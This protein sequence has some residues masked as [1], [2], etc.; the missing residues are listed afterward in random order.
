[1]LPTSDKPKPNRRQTIRSMLAG[2]VL[3][4]AAVTEMLRGGHVAA[5]ELSP[6]RPRKP[7]FEGKAKSLILLYMSGGVSHIET[8]DPKPQLAVHAGEPAPQAAGPANHNVKHLLGPNWSFRPGGTCGTPVSDLFPHLRECMD[9]ICLVRSMHSDHISHMEATL[10][11]HTGSF[12]VKRPSL[13]AWVSYGLGTINQNLPSFVVLAP[14]LPYGGDQ[15]WTADFLP[16]HHQG[17][18]IVAGAE[19]IANLTPQDPTSIQQR[20]LVF[21]QQMNR[22]HLSSRSTD[23]TLAARIQSFETAFGMQ[24]EMP[25]IVDLSRETAETLALYDLQPGQ[26]TGFGWQCLMARRMVERG[27]RFIELIDS[28]SDVPN[29]WDSHADIRNQH[30]PRAKDVDQPIAGLLKDLKRRG[31]LDET[32]VVWTTEFGRTP[33]DDGPQGRSHHPR[34]FSSWLAGAGVK[35]GMIYGQTDDLGYT[36]VDQEVHVHDFHATILH[37]LGFDHERL[38]YRHA[39]RDFR[40]TDVFG[41]V[42]YDL[43]A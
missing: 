2:S 8:F 29:N 35:G 20:E 13:G 4:P 10:G 31:L 11:I 22:Q 1:M 7:H 32:L 40:L 34:A 43:L 39:G 38:I 42:V 19:P 33:H 25:E 27:V 23:S 9:D 28:G 18:R 12:S 26:T 37:L 36:V 14:K 21:L 30:P 24:Q 16:A 41:N 5:S 17:T 6:L 3:L 15:C